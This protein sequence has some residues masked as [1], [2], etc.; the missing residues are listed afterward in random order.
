MFVWDSQTMTDWKERRSSAHGLA[1]SGLEPRPLQPLR[2]KDGISVNNLCSH[3]Y[4][5][6]GILA[7][8]PDPILLCAFGLPVFPSC[9]EVI[10]WREENCS[11]RSAWWGSFSNSRHAAGWMEVSSHPLAMDTLGH[12]HLKQS[13]LRV[14]ETPAAW[15]EAGYGLMLWGRE[16]SGQSVCHISART[17]V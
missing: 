16:L 1:H 14:V 2:T 3:C 8:Q 13:A 11:E 15:K 6:A 12:G 4:F 10:V 5:C 7:F 9:F 17:W